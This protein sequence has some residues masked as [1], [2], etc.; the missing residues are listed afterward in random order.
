MKYEI[1]K[2]LRQRKL[3]IIVTLALLAVYVYLAFTGSY[4]TFSGFSVE[5]FWENED[6]RQWMMAKET[7]MVDNEWIENMKAEYKAFVDTNMKTPEEIVEFIATKKAE[8][9]Q[10]DCTAEEALADR[11]NI[12]Y[13]FEILDYDAF[14]SREVEYTYLEAFNIY[15]PLAKDPAQFIRDSYEQSNYFWEKDTGM[16]YWEHMGYSDAQW[17]DYWTLIDTAYEDLD[18]TV[19]YSFGWDVLCS[20]MQFLPFTLG[21]ALIVTLGNIFSQEQTDNMRSILRTTKNG[22]ARLLRRKLGMAVIIASG[23]WLIF[24]LVMLTAISLSYTLHGANVTAM[25]FSGVPNLYG[26][27]WIQYYVINCVFSYLGTLVFALFVCCMSTLLKLRLSMP[28]N[29]V[30]TLL[31]GIPLNHFC[32]SDQAF[33]L[34]DKFRAITPAQLMASYPTLQVY[35]SYELGNIVIHL[36]FM[37]AIAIVIEAFLLLLLLRRREGGK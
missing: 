16:S 29:L 23:L 13:A 11:Y 22:R 21:M 12:D 1:V 6:Y 24:Q 26:L 19:G 25:C 35:Q 4:D 33:K 27:S 32:Y 36:P 8:G 9:F 17:S 37:M 30:L 5:Y 15:I 2:V 3:I 31:S 34:L 20:V 14:Q 10:I 18:V 7:E 28:I